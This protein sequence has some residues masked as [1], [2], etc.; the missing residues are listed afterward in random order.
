MAYA[1]KR[2]KGHN[3][4]RVRYKKPDGS[5]ATE[6]GFP[7]KTTA[8]NR[9]RELETDSRRGTYVDPKKGQTPF[10]EWARTWMDAQQVRQGTV[11]RR[12]YLLDR[13][14]LP[15]WAKT[16]LAHLN[17]FEV[18]AW[19]DRMTCAQSTVEHCLTLMSM[20]L[21]GAV[22][23]GALPANPLYRR[24]AA[25]KRA[26]PPAA[27]VFA[28]EGR[29]VLALYERAG[30]PNGLMMLTAAYTGLRWGEL[31]GLHREN[32]LLLR[33]DEERGDAVTRHVI[34]IDPEVGS[35]H[36]N[37]LTVDGR[38][39]KETVLELGPP[40]NAK[41]A[42]EVDVP[43]FLVD[44]LAA[45]LAEWPHPYVFCGPRG[46]FWR[47]SNFSRRWMRP[48]A[49]GRPAKPATQGRAATE[50]WEPI[51]PGLGMHGLR[52]THDTWMIEDGVDR[53]L[54]FE[55]MG[56]ARSDIEGVYGH[57]TPAMRRQRLAQLQQRWEAAASQGGLRVVS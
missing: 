3:P 47:R 32:C 34:R 16:P 55:T 11:E 30:T 12:E 14:I 40:K 33:R 17:W 38:P 4:W 35:L 28:T 57:V 23:A 5:W 46:G 20:T 31:A 1:E 25:G 39:A 13:H 29:Q 50:E 36:E 21:S 7:T 6:S 42:R 9:G 19:A 54:R 44:L 53:V 43:P 8:L 48:C 52:H 37:R 10:G 24:R 49:D 15:K 51:L 45:H 56:W 2:G 41:S 22:D 18:K 26:T 27:K